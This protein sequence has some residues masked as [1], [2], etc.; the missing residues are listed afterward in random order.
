MRKQRREL[1]KMPPK[2]SEPP[3]KPSEPPGKPQDQQVNAALEVVVPD[4]LMIGR[5]SIG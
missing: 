2:P 5:I 3:G 4:L 1:A